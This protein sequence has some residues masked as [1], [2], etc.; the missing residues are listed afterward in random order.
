[1]AYK[2]IKPHKMSEE[3][4]RQLWNDEYCN[5]DVYTHDGIHVKFYE[6]MFNHCF[7][8]SHDRKEK[9]K[10]ILSL[11]RLEKMLWI[12]ETLQD[13]EASLKKGWDRDTKTYSDDRRLAIVKYNYVVIILVF[14][15]KKARFM[16]AYEVTDDE[17]LKLI[18]ESP[19][20]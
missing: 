4:L 6:R 19:N 18:M 5:V 12:K 16:T 17:N 15:D 3:E 13:A 10:S 20:W 7:Y 2:K 1:M 11:N 8:E 14:K 9:D